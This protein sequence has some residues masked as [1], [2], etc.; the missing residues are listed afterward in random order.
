MLNEC[1]LFFFVFR[2]IIQLFMHLHCM[3]DGLWEQF[4]TGTEA[5]VEEDCSILRR[6]QGK[7]VV[8][9]RS[10]SIHQCYI[11]VQCW[12]ITSESHLC[13]W[14]AHLFYKDV[15][16]SYIRA[17]G[18]GSHK[19]R[20]VGSLQSMFGMKLIS[21]E[22]II[23]KFLPQKVGN[24]VSISTTEVHSTELPLTII[25]SAAIVHT[26]NTCMQAV[27]IMG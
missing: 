14:W 21:S 6:R 16:A 27:N 20:V 19:G 15:R 17:G 1:K 2:C 24:I 12:Q 8:C 11:R 22:A 26:N 10:R 3:H 4:W 5:E 9:S 25:T 23:L 18:P 7:E 13:F